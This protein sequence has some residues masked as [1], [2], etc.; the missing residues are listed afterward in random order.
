MADIL[1][2][3]FIDPTMADGARLD[4]EDPLDEQMEQLCN[5]P[6]S[7]SVAA[8]AVAGHITA[9]ASGMF[10]TTPEE[11]ASSASPNQEDQ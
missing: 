3:Q 11:V 8:S 4:E 2:T 5:P 1:A 6:S 7:S 10:Q 9:F